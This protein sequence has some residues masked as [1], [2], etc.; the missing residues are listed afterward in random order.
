MRY[1]AKGAER[2]QKAD[3]SVRQ[4]IKRT[5]QTARKESGTVKRWMQRHKRAL[6]GIGAAAA[7]ALGAIIKNTPALSA[8]LAEARLGFSLLAMTIGNDV[9]PITDELG[10]KVLDLEEAY[11]SLPDGIRKPIS[12]LI[13]FGAIVTGVVAILAGLETVI[14]GTLVAGALKT[15]GGGIFSVITSITAWA[16][17]IG[18]IIGAIGVWILKVTGVLDWIQNLGSSIRD[19]IGGPA[20]DL[21]IT[22]LTLTGI[23]PVLGVIGAAIIGFIEDGFSGMVDKVIEFLG[24][25]WDSLTNTFDNIVTFLTDT[26][27][28]W[29]VGA[30][31]A[32]VEAIKGVFEDF[33]IWM[34]GASFFPDLFDAVAEFIKNRGKQLL[35][36][37][38]GIA[39]DA[40]KGVV[41]AL[42]P[43]NWGADL[44]NE[45]AD[46]IKG[47]AGSVRDAA[48]GV[49]D[50]I[51][52]KIG[53]DLQKNDRMARR[54][55]SDLVGEFSDGMRRNVRTLENAL[56][57]IG[58]ATGLTR[59]ARGGATAGSAGAGG[60]RSVEITFERG[61]IVL[62]G[63]GETGQDIDRLVEEI[64]RRLGDEFGGRS[65]V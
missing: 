17:A 56:P 62:E 49:A 46:G 11:S 23:L 31:E 19:L 13:F 32:I 41:N 30:G 37:A 21:I 7:G 12:A 20:A 26:V 43:R 58:E 63:T 16:V 53:F 60:G 24:V 39:V 59:E 5:A 51:T 38:M 4:S 10:E 14:S 1:A 9:A 3:R 2:A 28:G 34:I 33:Y 61:A 57:A 29:F 18:V 50:S 27:V 47:A 36:G 25:L 48:G 42:D 22:I 55:G 8:T 52:D 64:K 65:R 44:M 35:T 15:L 45:M 6:V 54:W 40:V